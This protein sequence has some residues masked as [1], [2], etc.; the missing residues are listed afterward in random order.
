MTTLTIP[1]TQVRKNLFDLLE[2]LINP[3]IQITIT[4][5]G[6]P[7]AVLVN[8]EEFDSRQETLEIMADKELMA[9]I[10]A[11]EAEYKKGEYLTFEEVFGKTPT[12]VL[13]DKGKTKYQGRKN[14]RISNRHS[15]KSRQTAK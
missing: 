13:K 14:D 9:D 3:A 11:A 7:R 12:Q 2:K 10:K 5:R 15:Q 4:Y 1:A 8:A 6:E